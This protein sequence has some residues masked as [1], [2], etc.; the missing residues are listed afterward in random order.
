MEHILADH[1]I[2]YYE[3]IKVLGLRIEK[4]T[5]HQRKRAG[6]CWP[7]GFE[8]RHKTCTN[9]HLTW[10]KEYD[11]YMNTCWRE[12][13]VCPKSSHHRKTTWGK[14]TRLYHGF[15]GKEKYFGSR[16]PHYKGRG[17]KE[18][19][20]GMIHPKMH[21]AVFAPYEGARTGEWDGDGWLDEEVG[22]TWAD[23]NSP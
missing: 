14:W 15:Y 5:P 11:I 22:S 19:G 16:Y 20:W 13:G 8:H 23:K 12:Y 7:H 21:G 3:K 4:T 18:G 17:R 1:G 2:P 9:G 6:M 10:T